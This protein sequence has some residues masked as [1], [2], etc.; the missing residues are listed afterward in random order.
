[1]IMKKSWVYVDIKFYCFWVV[2]DRRVSYKGV[3]EGNKYFCWLDRIE[4]KR[5]DWYVLNFNV[6]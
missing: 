4:D 5:D 2:N 1:M 3:L 6:F